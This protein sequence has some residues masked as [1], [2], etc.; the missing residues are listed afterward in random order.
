[1]PRFERFVARWP[2]IEALAAARDEDVL[3]RMGRPW[4]L[5]ARPQPD[6]LRAR[7]GGGAAA[8]REPRRSC[9]SCRASAPIPRRRSPRS[10][11][12][13]RRA[14]VDT[15]VER[16]IARLQRPATARR[17]SEIER[18]LLDMMPADRP[19]D[20][21]QAMMDLGAT[22][23]RPKAPALRR[24][25]AARAIARAF[26]S[27]KPEAFPA[28]RRSAARPH[29][30]ASPG[31]SSA[32]AQSGW[33]AGP[34]RACSAEWRRCPASEW[35]RRAATHGAELGDGAPRLHPFLARP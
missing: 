30:T 6:R 1:M 2:T 28:P 15:N 8:F 26:A 34:P 27:G 33:C 7:G 20:F 18:R 5:C 3:S 29:A 14:A 31:G 16:V 11:S 13:S 35:T 10:R 19:G 9:A 21:V 25:P 24:L 22:I 12:A 32:T 23:C 4:L 17:G